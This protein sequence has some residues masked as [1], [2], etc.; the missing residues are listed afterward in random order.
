MDLVRAEG[1]W[2]E[3]C[4]LIIQAE[5]VLFRVSRDFLA[6]RSSIFEDMLS[7]P[8]PRDAE[9]MNGCPF[10]RLPDSAE[11]FA[12]FLKALVYSE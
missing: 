8:T 12:A 5:N 2:F 11:N 10:V 4:G 1:L 6:A 7:L 3:D 9:R